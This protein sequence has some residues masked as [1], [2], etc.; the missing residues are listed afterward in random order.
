ML[1]LVRVANNYPCSKPTTPLSIG[2][3]PFPPPVTVLVGNW[4]DGLVLPNGVDLVDDDM[5]KIEFVG[6][7]RPADGVCP[8]WPVLGADPPLPPGT[9]MAELFFLLWLTPTATPT[10]T[11]T[12]TNVMAIAIASPLFVRYQGKDFDWGL[13]FG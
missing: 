13:Y 9:A 4:V 6:S 7:A 3:I 11:P 5:G 8:A 10:I 2:M 1:D 12:T